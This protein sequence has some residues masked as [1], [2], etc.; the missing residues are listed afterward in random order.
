[1]PM[2]RQSASCAP[3]EALTPE[4]AFYAQWAGS[5]PSQRFGVRFAGNR[6]RYQTDRESLRG[7][8]RYPGRIDR[9]LIDTSK[10]DPAAIRPL[11]HTPGGA[12]GSARYKLA[13]RQ[14][15]GNTSA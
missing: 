15:R 6:R 14:D 12:F 2:E 3:D 13:N 11:R 8:A 7:P 9:D 1:M 4:N 5:P 10:E